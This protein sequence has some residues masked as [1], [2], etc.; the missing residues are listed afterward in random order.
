MSDFVC[1]HCNQS[2]GARQERDK[3][4]A[5]H[6]K[7]TDSIEKPKR[8]NTRNQENIVEDWKT[9]HTGEKQE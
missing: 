7:G 9:R 2:Y 6:F 8:D 1:P 3:C 4:I 5:E